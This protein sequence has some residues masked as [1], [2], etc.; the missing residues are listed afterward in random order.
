[1]QYDEHICCKPIAH[2][3][4]LGFGTYGRRPWVIECANWGP[5]L[6]FSVLSDS[7]CVESVPE[8]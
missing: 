5:F 6:S 7:L 4:Y 3:S 8:F 1:M 2:L